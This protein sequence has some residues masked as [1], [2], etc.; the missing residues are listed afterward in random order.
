MFFFFFVQV[1]EEFFY[2]STAK[3]KQCGN[4][5]FSIFTFRIDILCD[6]PVFLLRLTVPYFGIWLSSVWLT[7]QMTSHSS[8]QG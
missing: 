2:G 4:F 5:R 6:D 3:I 1:T 7:V 8:P